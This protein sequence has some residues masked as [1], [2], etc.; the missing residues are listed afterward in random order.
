MKI[1]VRGIEQQ[2][3]KKEDELA[4]TLSRVMSIRIENIRELK[5]LRRSLDARR[6]RSIPVWQY[7]LEV[8]TLSRPTR[9]PR[10]IS[11]HP[12]DEE[13]Q[14]LF[15][16]KDDSLRGTEALVVG[17]GPAGMFAA[18][19]LCRHGADV[20]IIEQGAEL[21]E[22]IGSTGELWR[23][24]KINES[25]NVQFGEGG[26]GTF[27]DGKL[28]FR[29]KT[30][31]ARSVLTSFVASGAPASILEDSHPHIGTDGVRKVVS[32]LRARIEN[33]GGRFSFKEKVIS[34]RP[35]QSGGFEVVTSLGRRYADILFLAIGH[36]SRALVRHLI[37][38]GVE[39][40]AKGFAVGARVE[41]PQAWVDS[42][43]YGR[44]AGHPDLPPA[45][46]RLTCKDEATGR[47]VYSFC[48][49]PGGMVVNAASEKGRLVTNGM[50]MS[51]RAA[52]RAN[53]GIIVTVHPEDFGGNPLKAIAFQEKLESA[54]F[55]L[56]GG[57][58]S[59]PVQSAGAFLKGI[60]DEEDIKVSFRPSARKVNLRGFFPDWIE[61]PLKRALEAFDSKMPGFIEE[62]VLMV[63]ETRTSS[64]VRFAR[65]KETLCCKGY[66]GLYVPGEGGGWS[67]GIVS[68]A[69]D[70]LRCVET[71]VDKKRGFTPAG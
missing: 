54:A 20:H 15:E 58:Y 57:D 39:V 26:A 19:S 27:S 53:A 23:T 38:I 22:R 31:E 25:T 60:T 21:K 30:V 48:M 64:P 29:N 69:A 14:S 10:G 2:I 62:G 3:G 50:S 28:T 67:G 68:S 11:W 43:Q 5:I 55:E 35:L 65:E 24:G 49:C 8:D 6:K 66:P 51:Q 17:T 41:H 42:C 45:E 13:S 1:R 71:L 70:A 9:C 46:Y 34:C 7:T 44:W 56:G 59:V 37:S 18:L 33:E 40:E 47:G 61:A 16:L 52:P 63:P 36:S 32:S 4:R 12:V